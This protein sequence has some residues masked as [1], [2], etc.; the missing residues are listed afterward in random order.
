MRAR[1]NKRA[2]RS[3]EESGVRILFVGDDA[4]PCDGLQLGWPHNSCEISVRPCG[5]TLKRRRTRRGYITSLPKEDGH[6]QTLR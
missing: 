4:V 1:S 6:V 2:G 5:S 3:Q